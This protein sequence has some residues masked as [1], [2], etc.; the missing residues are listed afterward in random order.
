MAEKLTYTLEKLEALR[1]NSNH[2]KFDA[3]TQIE[4][5]E[6]DWAVIQTELI[7]MGDIYDESIVTSLDQLKDGCEQAVREF[8]QEQFKSTSE[9]KKHELKT[10]RKAMR[11]AVVAG[12]SDDQHVRTH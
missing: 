12:T 10:M 11:S 5:F 8:A 1:E 2:K 4:K 7:Q 6:L 9:I 3:T